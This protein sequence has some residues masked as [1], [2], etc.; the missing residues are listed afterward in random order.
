MPQQVASPRKLKQLCCPRK[1]RTE[2][3]ANLSKVRQCRNFSSPNGRLSDLLRSSYS[4]LPSNLY[5]T[6][7][8]GLLVGLLRQKEIT[9]V[10]S[11]N[12]MP[13]ARRIISRAVD[14]ELQEAKDIGFGVNRFESESAPPHGWTSGKNGLTES[15]ELEKH[16]SQ[17][18]L[19]SSPRS[20]KILSLSSELLSSCSFTP[21]SSHSSIEDIQNFPKFGSTTKKTKVLKKCR[22][23]MASLNDVSQKYKESISALGNSIFRDDS[24]K[25]AN[26]G[27]VSEVV[28]LMI[29]FVCSIVSMML[30]YFLITLILD[31]LISNSLLK[32]KLMINFLS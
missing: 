9:L 27:I 4:R 23:I 17:A 32:R 13:L 12:L 14:Y 3:N 15:L 18:C 5:V 20:K 21:S 30:C 2:V 28:V 11:C 1:T 25:E 8:F 10:R 16:F 31:T 29:L 26:K 7:T 22:E 6:S 24:E 19:I